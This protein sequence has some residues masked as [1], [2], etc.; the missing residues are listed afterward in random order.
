MSRRLALLFP[1]LLIGGLIVAGQ[2]FLFSHG[3]RGIISDG[4][5]YWSYLPSYIILDDPTFKAFSALHK[6]DLA[7]YGINR[8]PDGTYIEKY[9]IGVALLQLPFFLAAD[10][11]AGNSSFE[12]DGYSLP[13]QVASSA[14]AATYALLGLMLLMLA[15]RPY[16]SGLS[17]GLAGVFLFLGTNAYHYATFDGSFSHIFTFFLASALLYVLFTRRQAHRAWTFP[18]GLL[19]GLLILVRP[20]NVVYFLFVG[21]WVLRDRFKAGR[22]QG[23]RKAVRELVVCGLWILPVFALQMA[24]W[25]ASTGK[26]FTYPYDGEYFDF[27]SPHIAD[28]LFSVRK[29]LFFWNPMY[30][31]ALTGLF[32]VRLPKGY[33]FSAL[34]F[35]AAH[36]YVTSS[37]HCWWYGGTLGQRV[38]VDALPVFYPGL[39]S[40]VSFKS[41]AVRRGSIALC[42][43]VT[44]YSLFC[45]WYLWVGVIPADEA[46]FGHLRSAWRFTHGWLKGLGLP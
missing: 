37:W 16:Y 7:R 45:T 46:G 39:V 19:L 24:A 14:G 9:P 43:V 30:L 22:W 18:A 36:T 11:Y 1:L 5:G 44:L 31:L 27:T 29:G 12:R 40:L 10:A 33:L 34:V 8:R 42:A 35:L 32:F 15:L 25:H 41:R 4:E 6:D 17:L 26:W 23:L 38:F 2:G 21:C 28:V 3:V 20:T 13:Y